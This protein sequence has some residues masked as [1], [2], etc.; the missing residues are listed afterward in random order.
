MSAQAGLDILIPSYNRASL[1]RECL[2]SLFR[3]RPPAVMPW[4]VTVIDN[5]STDNTASVVA[6]FAKQ[7][8]E[9]ARYLFEPQQGKSAALNFGIQQSTRELVGMIDDDEQVGEG[10]L[11]TI[12]RW[13][14]EPSLDYIG[15]PYLALWR[16]ERPAWLPPSFAGVL[17]ADDPENIPREPCTFGD[18]RVFLRGGNAVLRRSVLD[19]IGPYDTALGRF[20]NGMGSCE[21][22]DM[23]NRLLAAGSKG[24]YVPDLIIHHIVP[25]ERVTRRYYRRWAFGQATSLARM[26]KRGGR[27]KVTYLGRVPRYILGEAVKALP[28]LAA[29]SPAQR[30]DAELRWWTVAGFVTGAYGR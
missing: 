27:Q 13:F 30:F 23:F 3:A 7:Y 20:G 6:S 2:E 5:N 29:R 16:A 11:R 17:G 4:R 21:D 8:G 18:P 19:R 28:S 24:I 10:W 12:E 1:L 9:Q 22:H 26:E 15:G 14:Q 25:R